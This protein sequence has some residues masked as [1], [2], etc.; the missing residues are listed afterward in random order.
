MRTSRCGHQSADVG[1]SKKPSGLK[2]G[3]QRNMDVGKYFHAGLASLTCPRHAVSLEGPVS[4][5]QGTD[6]WDLIINFAIFETNK[7]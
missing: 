4:H 1:R 2:G 7:T 5:R 6:A 3:L